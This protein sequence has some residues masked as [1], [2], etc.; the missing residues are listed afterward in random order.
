MAFYGYTQKAKDYSG[1]GIAA[2]QIGQGITGAAEAAELEKTQQA[3]IDMVNKD[4][5]L[6]ENAYKAYVTAFKEDAT[7]A[8]WTPEQIGTAVQKIGVPTKTGYKQSPAGEFKRLGDAFMSLKEQTQQQARQQQAQQLGQQVVSPPQPVPEAGAAMGEPPGG[9][10][11]KDIL[12]QQPPASREQ[13][14]SQFAAGT[15]EFQPTPAETTQFGKGVA[16]QFAP[17][18][19]S[20]SQFE[21]DK[22]QLQKDKFAWDKQKTR[23]GAKPQPKDYDKVLQ[24]TIGNKN[25]AFGLS[26]RYDSL[27]KATKQTIKKAEGGVIDQLLAQKLIELGYDGPMDVPSLEESLN[28]ME[29]TKITA[30]QDV[31]FYEQ[32]LKEIG[33]TERPTQLGTFKAATEK[34]EAQR[35]L[36]DTLTKLEKIRGFAYYEPTEPKISKTGEINISHPEVQEKIIAALN[37]G[38]DVDEIARQLQASAAKFIG[39]QTRTP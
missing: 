38:M 28:Q 11:E 27:I 4:F 12:A 8:G 36:P 9:V 32:Q 16:Q 3:A 14:V 7:K 19:K 31:K 39:T 1:I 10:A 23:I 33:K 20:V 18:E 5:S 24:T 17:A 34:V 15:E 13:A 25:K 22:F 35:Q 6:L 29:Q 30:D 21:K 37:A 2:G 26:A